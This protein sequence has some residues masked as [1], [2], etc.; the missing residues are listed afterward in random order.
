MTELS[1]AADTRTGW[2]SA[3]LGALLATGLA[4][5]MIG[6]APAAAAAASVRQA[7]PAAAVSGNLAA[8]SCAGITSC[9]AVGGRSSTSTASGGTLAEKWNGTAWSVVSS[10]NPA[11]ADGAFFYGVDCTSTTNC[12]AVGVYFTASHRPLPMAEKWNGSTWSLVTVPAPSGSTDASLEAIACTSA[13]ACHGVGSSMDKTLAENWNGTAWSIVSSPSPY[14]SE[15]NI[16]SGVSCA[17]ASLCFAVGYDFPNHFSGSLTE[18]WN[19]KAW[20]V[21]STPSS[22]SGE[23]TGDDCASATSCMSVGISNSLFALAQRWN[24]TKWT[25]ATPKRPAGATSTQ[26]NAVSCTS[27]TACQ[28]AG[29]YSLP[30]GNPAL[31]EGWNGT[32]WALE[33]TPAISGSTFTTLTGI[34]CAGASLCWAAG[35]WIGS[36]GTATP[37]L[38]KWNGKTWS[39]AS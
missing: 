25:A 3:L 15:A 36:G 22:K 9:V 34:S 27:A 17:S 38:D 31:A 1:R 10:P 13:T 11:G 8:V 30:S 37:L 20:S 6:P 16:L 23:L 39:L 24:G 33:K 35:E 7:V 14:P 12:L 4:A 32:A 28:A 18:E 2:P 29:T 26:L 5:A 19:G 21:V